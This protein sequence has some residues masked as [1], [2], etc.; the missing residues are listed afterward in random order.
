MGRDDGLRERLNM[1]KTLKRRHL[2][3]S[4][5]V[6]A[7]VVGAAPATAS[8][9]EI[10]IGEKVSGPGTACD[11]NNASN[12]HVKVCFQP[13]GEWLYVKD[14]D[15]DG[16]SAYRINLMMDDTRWTSDLA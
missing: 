13:G 10:V 15:D 11:G 9:Q 3:L 16:R 14:V 5:I 12:G 2:P 1:R 4:L 6:A 7:L 8:A